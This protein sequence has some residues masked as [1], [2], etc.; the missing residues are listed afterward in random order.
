MT[1]TILW[2]DDEIDLLKPY[3]I[4]LKEKGYEVVT[5]N[6]GHDALD[7][8]AEKSFDI[9]FLDENMP[10][11]SGLEVLTEISKLR[12]GMP[13]VMIT[14][15]EEEDIMDQ[16]IGQ[17]I[18]D[19]LIKPVNPSQILLT[20][21]KHLHK[22]EIVNTQN[23]TTFRNEFQQLSM[24]IN[25]KLTIKEW[26]DLHRRLTRWDL[27]LADGDEGLHSMLHSVVEDANQAF[28]K[29]VRN[30]YIQ[31]M[32]GGDDAPMLSWDI[33][34]KRIFPLLD[35]GEKV[36]M[37]VIDNMRYDQWSVIQDLLGKSFTITQNELYCSILPTATQ[38]ARNAIFAGLTPLQI[39]KR[40][41]DWWVEEVEEEGKNLHEF[42][43]L[44]EQLRR[45]GRDVKVSYQKCGNSASIEQASHNLRRSG[46]ELCVAVVNFVDMLSHAR[47]DNK[48]IREL[49]S[50][51]AAYRSLT[52]EWIQ[53]SGLIEMFNIM[54]NKGYKIIVTTDH[55]TTQVDHALKVIGDRNTSVSLRYKVGKSINFDRKEL[56]EIFEIKKPEEIGLPMPNLSSTYIF[57]TG[58]CFLAY[59]NNY[60]YY[61][62]YYKDTFQH[63]G[64]SMEEML[65]PLV[66]MELSL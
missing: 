10:G 14:K 3:T 17:H 16:A 65:I 33:V 35:N 48:M 41:P 23:I 57:A 46:A 62:T 12:Q 39:A 53:R 24:Y 26:Y 44:V 51:E 37:V 32:K 20:L 38:Y 6:N 28:Q 50:S 64:I 52:R 60:N 13:V 11:V 25:D 66:Q 4:F 45:N 42:E 21:K 27:E 58:K 19:F 5:C 8:V 29:F 61:V 22:Q 63:G 31:W 40:Y 1:P 43:M 59:P 49:A 7:L 9:M 34:R 15:N 47:T 18:A 30:N 36:L 55:G 54:G 56:K 2:V